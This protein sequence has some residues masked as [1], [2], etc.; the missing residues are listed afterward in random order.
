MHRAQR[1][2]GVSPV[3]QSINDY[4]LTTKLIGRVKKE[5]GN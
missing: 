2:T 1:R 3:Y 5:K 4:L